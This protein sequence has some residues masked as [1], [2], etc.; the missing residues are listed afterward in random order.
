MSVGLAWQLSNEFRNAKPGLFIDLHMSLRLLTPMEKMKTTSLEGSMSSVAQWCSVLRQVF[1]AAR[2]AR[3]WDFAE[4]VLDYE[5]FDPG[6]IGKGVTWQLQVLSVWAFLQKEPGFHDVAQTFNMLNML[7]ECSIFTV[8]NSFCLSC[9]LPGLVI[10]PRSKPLV[11]VVQGP[12]T[13]ESR[14]EE[15]VHYGSHDRSHGSEAPEKKPRA[16]AT[17]AFWGGIQVTTC[18]FFGGNEVLRNLRLQWLTIMEIT[19]QISSY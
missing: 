13:S 8:T 6:F 10:P 16:T 9:Y 3:M 14:E 1:S 17:W 4:V 7:L 18:C 12:R 15:A 5:L 2:T 19:F 11:P